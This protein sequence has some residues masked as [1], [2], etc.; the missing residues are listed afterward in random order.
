MSSKKLSDRLRVLIV[1]ENASAKFGGE[2]SLP[3]HYFRQFRARQIE[4]WLIA[5]DRTRHELET[6]FPDDL[7]RLLFVP[8]T[9]WHRW[10]HSVG[11]VFPARL[12]NMTFGFA[13]NL[14]SQMIQRRMIQKIAQRHDINIIHQPIPVSPKQPSLLFNLGTPIV[15]GPMN[16]GMNY[17]PAFQKMEHRVTQYAIR[18]GRLLSELFNL[19]MPGKCKAD[20]LLVANQRT[21]KA[22]PKVASS[23]VVELV[24][25]GVDL[26]IW[27]PKS[28]VIKA[29]RGTQ[30]DAI[31]TQPQQIRFIFVGRLV[32]WKAVDLL[33]EAFN[34]IQVDI[35]IVLEIIGNGPERSPLENQAERLGLRAPLEANQEQAGAKHIEFSGWLSQAECAR[36]LQA[37][38]VMV[39]PSLLECGGAVVLEAMAVGL[40]VIA[41][42]WGGP[43]D[44]VD[45]SCGILVEPVSR[46]G[47]IDGLTNA[48]TKLALSPDLRLSMGKA[49][50]EK[51]VRQ[52]NW[53]AK[54]DQILDCYQSI[55]SPRQREE[56]IPVLLGS[57]SR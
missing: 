13:M 29:L 23:N 36:R 33:I 55:L 25:N 57:T 43:A 5:H 30:L 45:A 10:L 51:A 18:G 56:A 38:N 44:Y 27:H 1:A 47:F 34:C 35:P 11:K 6:L 3:M 7:D 31:A 19:L 50:R 49:G 41:T 53:E 32:D 4:T 52:F 28:E 9:I 46:A 42:N 22:L 20:L 39:L 21:R 40:P 54:T 16:G 17:P 2:A 14:L 26:S 12:R 48:M 24:E 37:A 15:F 8:D